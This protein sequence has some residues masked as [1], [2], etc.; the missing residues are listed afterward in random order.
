[1]DVLLGGAG[2]DAAAGQ[3]QPQGEDHHPN[4][5]QR[6]ALYSLGGEPAEDAEGD[7][8]GRPRRDEPGPVQADGEQQ[9]ADREG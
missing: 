4:D 9:Q 6:L 8:A 2:E 7:Q 1:M 3:A 5:H